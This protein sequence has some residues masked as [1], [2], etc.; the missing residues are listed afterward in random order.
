MI[1]MQSLQGFTG[2][3]QHCIWSQCDNFLVVVSDTLLYIYHRDKDRSGDFTCM[4]KFRPHD[5]PVSDVF[6]VK[7]DM[8]VDPEEVEENFSN[9]KCEYSFVSCSYDGTIAVWRMQDVMNGK[10]ADV[11][12]KN[13]EN[14]P[15]NAAGWDSNVM[16]YGVQAVECADM[17]GRCAYRDA[18]MHSCA[19]LADLYK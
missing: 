12:D 7:T 5:Y 9:K 18:C 19:L 13:E 2:W 3:V 15:R 17:W 14:R 10:Y 11:T 6:W 1:L 16:S 4:A 8:W